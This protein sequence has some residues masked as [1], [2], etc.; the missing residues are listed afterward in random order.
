MPA[1]EFVR[2]C[3]RILGEEQL[4]CAGTSVEPDNGVELVMGR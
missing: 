1:I 4:C 2:G 3:C